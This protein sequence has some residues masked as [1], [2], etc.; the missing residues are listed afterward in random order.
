MSHALARHAQSIT[1]WWKGFS[2]AG[3]GLSHVRTH[4]QGA[5]HV[6]RTSGESVVIGAGLGVL[7]SKL[8]SLDY[9]VGKHHIPLDAALGVLGMLAAVGMAREEVATDLRN[10]G[11]TGLSVFAYRKG[12]E[13]AEKKKSGGS[14][15]SG[16]KGGKAAVHGDIGTVGYH[17][18]PDEVA[19]GTYGSDPIEAAASKLGVGRTTG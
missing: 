17:G 13:W 14:G 6:V 12:K 2:A 4:V 5:G 9:Q 19:F 11:A 18:D 15:D 16:G 3:T 10:A 1:E 8:G 7:E